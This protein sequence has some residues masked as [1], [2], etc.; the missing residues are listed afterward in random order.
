VRRVALLF[1]GGAVWLFLAAIPV[2]ADGGPHVASI[3][4]GTTAAGLTADSCAGCHRAH[5]AQA[6][7]L[8][9]EEEPAMCLVCHGATSSGATTDVASGVQYQPAANGTRTATLL[10][11]LRNGGF[12]SARIGADAAYRVSYLSGTDVRQKAKVP[13]GASETVTSAHMPITGPGSGIAWGN[14]D[15]SFKATA[16]LGATVT[17]NCTTCHNPH[18]NGKYRILNPVPAPGAVAGGGTF[19]K[20]A[21]PGVSVTDVPAATRPN[22]ETLNYTVI[23]LFPGTT[24]VLASQVTSY[25]IA[26]GD[27]LHRRVPWDKTA[28]GTNGND[29]PNGDATNFNAQMNAWCAT[30]HTRISTSAQVGYGST[31]QK[32]NVVCNNTTVNGSAINYPCTAADGIVGGPFDVSS[33]DAVFKYRHPTTS[34]KPCTTCHVAHGSN[35]AMTGTTS[36]AFEVV[37]GSGVF[38]D[39]SFLLKVDNRGTCQA[40]HDPTGTTV[41]GST[42]GPA[43]NPVTP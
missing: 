30:C 20:V 14:S 25:G 10:G 6:E 27:Y 43:P 34:N 1:A 29:A 28:T 37:P 41:D 40:C 36:G 19:V 23:Q 5:T 33:G 24:S 17:I 26:A 42:A 2:L 15:G 39:S 13:V 4:S 21:A 32:P 7:M 16:D 8:L 11:A 22:N 35:A 38:D 12:V 3:N 9:T 18:G 31:G